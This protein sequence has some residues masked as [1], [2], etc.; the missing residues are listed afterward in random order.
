MMMDNQAVQLEFPFDGA[1]DRPFADIAQLEPSV[2]PG[3]IVGKVYEV[4]GRWHGE[5]GPSTGS[6]CTGG[7]WVPQTCSLLTAVFD[8]TKNCM[9]G[10]RR[11]AAIDGVT[12]I[13]EQ[14]TGKVY[15]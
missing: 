13:Y 11:H 9:D 4:G 3:A 1:Q 7:W 2:I 6:G 15:A 10:K 14:E 5:I 8:E 12:R